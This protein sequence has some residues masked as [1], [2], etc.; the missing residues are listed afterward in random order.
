[1][2]FSGFLV[3]IGVLAE[4]GKVL[5]R[6]VRERLDVLVSLFGID[7]GVESGVDEDQLLF[8]CAAFNGD[9]SRL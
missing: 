1:M 5:G 2:V 7:F 3:G 8:H 9:T 6:G 4:P